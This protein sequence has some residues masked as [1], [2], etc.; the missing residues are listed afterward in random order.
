MLSRLAGPGL[1][2]G[3]ACGPHARLPGAGA[4]AVHRRCQCAQCQNVFQHQAQQIWGP[5][6]DAALTESAPGL[7]LCYQAFRSG[8]H[9]SGRF[10]FAMLTCLARASLKAPGVVSLVSVEPP[11]T[12]PPA[13]MVSGAIST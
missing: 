3:G 9:L 12:V 13:P 1:L 10:Q 8:V 2:S 6:T 5:L 11:P 7:A 4:A